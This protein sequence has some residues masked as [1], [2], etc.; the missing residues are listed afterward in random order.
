MKIKQVVSTYRNDFRAIM[1]C[2]H[3]GHE[4]NNNAGYNDHYYHFQ[5]IPAMHC[6]ECKKNRA[7][8]VKAEV[9]HEQSK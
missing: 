7:G 3:C 2:E 6:E 9:A 5:V 4:H 8:E 1:E